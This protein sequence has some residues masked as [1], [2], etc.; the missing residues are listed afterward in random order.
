[1]KRVPAVAALQLQPAG[2]GAAWQMRAAGPLGDL[3]NGHHARLAECCVERLDMRDAIEQWDN[4][5]GRMHR[6][7]DGGNA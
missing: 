2:S 5:R 7:T 3:D 4:A 6:R 1:M